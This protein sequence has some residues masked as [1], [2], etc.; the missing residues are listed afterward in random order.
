M[1]YMPRVAAA[2]V[3]GTGSATW[4][5]LI[6]ELDRWGMAGR[7][8]GLWWRD[9][10]AVR[11]TAALDR[12]LEIAAGIPLGLAVIPG[13]VEPEL[14][15]RLTAAPQVCV[16]QHG[17][18]HANHGGDGRKSEYPG[19]RAEIAVAAEMA[20]GRARLRQLFGPRALPIFVPPWNR[21]AE[22]WLP[23]LPAAGLAVL[24]GVDRPAPPMPPP[25]LARLDIHIDLVAWHDGGGFIGAP[26]ALGGVVGQ[27]QAR[28]LGATAPV[29]PIGV[30][31]HHLVTD[32]AGFDFL[33]EL[34]AVIDGHPA[35]HW[36]DPRQRG[37][38]P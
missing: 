6:A 3:A 17:W 35:A 16:L 28:R 7:L 13:D 36:F 15:D 10:D 20:D 12:L 9:D 11:P 8:A 1:S 5:D 4:S 22:R 37:A 32:A 23:L 24:S 2:P 18:R 31:T 29:T 26:A 33:G 21:I 34:G 27:L 25:G 38:A 30:L 19:S 14:A